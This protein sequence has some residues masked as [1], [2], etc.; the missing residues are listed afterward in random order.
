MRT[1]TTIR[2][3]VL[4]A[5]LSLACLSVRADTTN[6]LGSGSVP[7][8]DTNAFP[9]VL[10]GIIDTLQGATNLDYIV[11]GIYAPS[12]GTT[13]AS[14]GEGFGIVYD[15]TSQLGAVL[16]ADCINASGHPTIWLP[17]G[18]MQFQVPVKITHS[19]TLYP[20][21][22]GGIAS[23]ISGQG[24]DNHAVV[25]ITGGGVYIKLNKNWKLGGDWEIWN[26]NRQIRFG[27]G[28]GF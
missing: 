26:G 16:R 15:I 5:I 10:T 8:T 2:S 3:L 25:T 27:G 4:F 28:F 21:G 14:W 7:T 17:S 22:F 23:A 20:F 11:Y 19:L 13:G 24:A 12:H 6:L 1:R 9:P 18:T